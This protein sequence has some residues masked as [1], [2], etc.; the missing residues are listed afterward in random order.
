MGAELAAKVRIDQFS[1]VSHL[2]IALCKYPYY[3]EELVNVP[4]S[5]RQSCVVGGIPLFL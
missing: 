1:F 2:S 4:K 5:L 3:R